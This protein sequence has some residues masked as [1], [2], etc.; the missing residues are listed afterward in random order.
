MKGPIIGKKSMVICVTPGPGGGVHGLEAT[1]EVLT[2]LAGT[3][4]AQV[5]AG[6][7]HE[8]LDATNTVTDAE[9]ADRLRAGLAAF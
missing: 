1:A 2:L 9:L 8:K 4:V 6:G 5:T 7:I 3:V